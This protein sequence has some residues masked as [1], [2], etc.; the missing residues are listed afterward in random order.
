[1]EKRRTKRTL[2]KHFTYEKP[3]GEVSDRSLFVLNKPS[4]SYFGLDLSEFT[5]EERMKYN[6]MLKRLMESVAEEIEV[7]GLKHNYRRFKEER[8]REERK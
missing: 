3:D 5:V 1:M 6:K 4:D 7:M 8:I 2:M